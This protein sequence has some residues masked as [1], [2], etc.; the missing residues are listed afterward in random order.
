MKTPGTRL[1][2][3]LT[4]LLWFDLW[5]FIK[6]GLEP[7]PKF[8]RNGPIMPRLRCKCGDS[9]VEIPIDVNSLTL[10]YERQG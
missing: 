9:P 4:S 8:L 3:R 7:K 2:P 6:L 5:I 10:S 1:F